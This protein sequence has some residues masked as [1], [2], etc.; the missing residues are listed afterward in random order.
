MARTAYGM[1]WPMRK[2]FTIGS[3]LAAG[4][5]RLL[6]HKSTKG[7]LKETEDRLQQ[8]QERLELMLKAREAHKE[9]PRCFGAHID[10]KMEPGSA[11]RSALRAQGGGGG[12]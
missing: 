9:F 8:G 5:H 2:V 3:S 10:T 4:N 12:G 1:E 6:A 7:Q 11:G